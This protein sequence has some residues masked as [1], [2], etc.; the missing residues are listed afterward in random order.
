MLEQRIIDQTGMVANYAAKLAGVR[1]ELIAFQK[2]QQLVN[3]Q[4][5][6]DWKDLWPRVKAQS[7]NIPPSLKSLLQQGLSGAGDN[8]KTL[9]I[10]TL[11]L[12]LQGTDLAMSFNPPASS[13]A[14]ES[15]KNNQTHWADGDA[16]RYK[17][18]LLE[19]CIPELRHR[20]A[21]VLEKS[22]A[23]RY[24]RP[25]DPVVLISGIKPSPRHDNTSPQTTITNDWM[26]DGK[27]GLASWQAFEALSLDKSIPNTPGSD[28]H[29]IM[30]DWAIEFSP[31][32]KQST[33]EYGSDYF[34]AYTTGAGRFFTRK[35]TE[36]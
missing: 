3:E 7:L 17:R 15:L 35:N 9:F 8:A 24:W 26:Q 31:V 1:K 12:W 20:P 11:N 5:I 32:S 27:M 19:L 2:Q 30:M 34:T 10:R 33:N 22:A 13:E 28:W 16:I 21:L 18:L 6:N 36:V 14:Y 4:D 23:P 29:P 25:N